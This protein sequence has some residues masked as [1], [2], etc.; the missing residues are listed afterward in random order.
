[1]KKQKNMPRWVLLSFCALIGALGFLL[2]YGTAPLN[3][4]NDTW[5]LNGYD[6]GDITQHYAG[7]LAFRNS[8]WAFP[9]G[10]A[11]NASIPDGVIISYTDSIPWAAILCKLLRG[12]LP[13]TWQYFGLYT[14]LCFVLQGLAAGLLVSRFAKSD[15][16]TVIS[17]TLFVFAP[18]L[19]DRALRHTALAS[20]WLILFALYFYL[21]YRQSLRAYSCA[22]L[23]QGGAGVRPA[24]FPWQCFLLNILA[25][26]LHPYMMPITMLFTLLCCIERG[27]HAMRET[28]LLRWCKA[29]A[30]LLAALA[31]T[32]FAGWCIG[33]VGWTTGD[34]REGFGFYSMNLNAIVN[35][36]SPFGYR[37]SRFLPTLPQGL[38]QYEGFN[39]LGLGIL[40]LLAA[41]LMLLIHRA[42]SSPAKAQAEALAWVQ[43]NAWLLAAMAFLTLFALSNTL[44]LGD[45]SFTIPLPKK[46]LELCGLFRS[47]GRMFY[48]VWYLLL[49]GGLFVLSR[50]TPKNLTSALLLVAACVQILDLSPVIVQKHSYMK[51]AE[52]GA[53][54]PEI[55]QNET[56]LS[57]G[58]THSKLLLTNNI[59]SRRDLA[60]LAGRQGMACNAVLAT[61]GGDYEGA[62]NSMMEK[63]PA[64]SL[65]GS[66]DKDTVYVTDSE[67]IFEAWQQMYENE[68]S[69]QLL[70][71]GEY[72]FLIP[73]E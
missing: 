27:C 46:L 25:I 9:L 16:F 33:V 54:V 2:V 57:M 32:V 35:P 70:Q 30:L 58:K 24:A 52:E 53:L 37:W 48:T 69:V 72:W 44:S 21:Q 28:A 17:S 65:S 6:E 7:W 59:A 40:L 12:V 66:P 15:L 47:S 67:G 60:V 64:E 49:L 1:M 55:F 42:V 3:P 63:A 41:A 29:A 45:A 34:S 61:G 23:Q 11:A 56:L 8:P 50:M 4:A 10:Y 36:A 20:H 43:K 18:I 68:P 26:G 31:S 5:L 13:Q 39:Y 19:L 51:L 38:G 71:A 14:L 73:Q 62:W 22:H